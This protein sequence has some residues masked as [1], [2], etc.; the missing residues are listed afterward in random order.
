MS[1]PPYGG[2]PPRTPAHRV[3]S[4][5]TPKKSSFLW[6][7]AKAFF[8]VCIWG[9]C[10]AALSILWFSYD[11]PSVQQLQESH[12]KPSV[13][14]QSESGEILA[15]YGD[16][17]ANLVNIKDLPPYVYQAVLA[18]EDR[19]FFHHF[20]L[21]FIGLLRAAYENYR[22]NRVVQGGSTITQQLGKNFL[23]AQGLYKITDRSLRRKVQEA[24]M[25]LW[26]EWNF[27]KEQILTIYLNR[28]YLGSGTYGIDA[29]AQKYFNTTANN[30]NVY[31]AALI[32]GLLK[33]PSRYSP[34]SHP[35]RSLER[36]AVVLHQMA[37]E[38]Y[39]QNPQHYIDD[40]RKN[41][42]RRNEER[43][44]G[45][46]SNVKFFTDWIYD[47][48]S[49]YVPMDQ[50]LVVTT[51]LNPA[52][53]RHMEKIC[54]EHA[55]KGEDFKASEVAMV[56]M[57]KKGAVR[58]MMG[59]YNYRKSQFNRATQ[60]LRQSGSTFKLFVYLA[61]LEHGFTPDTMFDDSPVHIGN[62][63]PSSFKWRARGEITMREGFAYSVNPVTVRVGYAAGAKKILEVAHRLGITSE[64][65][66]NLSITLGAMDTTLMQLT[67][68]FATF[69]NKGL[70]VWPYG[71]VEIKNRQGQVLYKRTEGKPIRVVARHHFDHMY[72]MLS[73]VVTWGTGRAAKTAKGGK[74]GSNGDRDAW[75]LGYTDDLVGGVWVGN[76]NC[77][78]MVKKSVG[79]R[80]PTW[81]WEAYYSTLP[82]VLSDQ[83]PV[84][85]VDD[86][87]D[88]FTEDE[89]LVAEAEY[90]P[91]AYDPPPPQTLSD[92][93]L[94]NDRIVESLIETYADVP[95]TEEMP[96]NF[97]QERSF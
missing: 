3:P 64:P 50:D 45:Q 51:T 90:D 94:D 8:T 92:D 54:A 9:L 43:M 65:K 77:S 1:S 62:W 16:L 22:A 75:F 27:T 48:L 84:E 55:H 28:V 72:S 17:H 29:A 91:R 39:I 71:I 32:A 93:D 36:G 88:A 57:T 14:I 44:L 24:I 34:L 82:K 96:V 41:L 47:Q 76:D 73:S 6:I 19:R 69:A 4:P 86:L 15:T 81:I 13:V 35:E 63:S 11:L 53:Q 20:G 42:L 68:A 58:A 30:L 66:N 5:R 97:Q 74:S 89:N 67:S 21:D 33:A 23:Q 7:L 12:R 38:G 60:A 49:G 56:S 46:H 83:A 40:A 79:G 78:P 85:S 18:I 61:G 52:M 25:A 70:S 59:G 31:Q 2:Q 37:E 95:A 80:L 10:A 87:I 26:L